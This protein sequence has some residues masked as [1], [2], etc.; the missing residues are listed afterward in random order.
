M[1]KSSIYPIP[2]IHLTPDEALRATMLTSEF[3]F[4]IRTSVSAKF[5]MIYQQPEVNAKYLRFID[6]KGELLAYFA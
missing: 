5:D 2:E 3:G 4:F 1:T 6:T